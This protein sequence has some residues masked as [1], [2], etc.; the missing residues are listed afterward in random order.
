[1]DRLY[2]AYVLVEVRRWRKCLDRRKVSWLGYAESA[3]LSLPKRGESPDSSSRVWP[4]ARHQSGVVRQWWP[5]PTKSWPSLQSVRVCRW[6]FGSLRCDGGKQ[7]LAFPLL[8]RAGEQCHTDIHSV[9][10]TQDGVIML[11]GEDFCRCHHT[12]LAMVVQSQQHG[13]QCD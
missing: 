4:V 5:V 12:G 3:W 9:Q 13:K 1:M 10:E 7:F 2:G 8:R 11:S 6:V